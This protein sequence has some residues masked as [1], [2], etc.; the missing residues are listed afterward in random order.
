MKLTFLHE[1]RLRLV[2]PATTGMT[3]WQFRQFHWDTLIGAEMGAILRSLPALSFA[4]SL[5]PRG[6]ESIVRLDNNYAELLACAILK[7]DYVVEFATPTGIDAVG[8][9]RRSGISP[10]AVPEIIASPTASGSSRTHGRISWRSSGW[11]TRRGLT[12]ISR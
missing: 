4:R 5:D 8:E 3:A 9:L 7:D 11:E 2:R 12:D 6:T 10:N 1:T